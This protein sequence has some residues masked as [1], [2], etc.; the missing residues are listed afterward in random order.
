M[1]A[2]NLCSKRWGNSLGHCITIPSTPTTRLLDRRTEYNWP[3]STVSPES[4]GG[5]WAFYW[6]QPYRARLRQHWMCLK[7]FTVL[8]LQEFVQM[9]AWFLDPRGCSA[10]PRLGKFCPC[11]R[12]QLFVLG[13]FKI[14]RGENF[15]GL[16][17]SGESCSGAQFN[18]HTYIPHVPHLRNVRISLDL[19]LISLD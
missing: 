9:N 4:G 19:A 13:N 6:A 10:F 8:P 2:T 17:A 3:S 16:V 18:S 11:P 15:Q 5:H 7:T 1:F 14:N 12:Q